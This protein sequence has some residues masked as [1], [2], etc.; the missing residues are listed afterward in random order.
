MRAMVYHQYGT[1]D[2]LQLQ[3]IP[4]PAVRD[5]QVL[6]S[7][8]AASVNAIDWH[9]LAGTPF[10]AR[11]MAGGLFKPKNGVLG[12]DLAGRVEATG[13]NVKQFQPGDPVFG[14]TKHGCFAE[15]VCVS[16]EEVVTKPAS[17]TFEEAAAAGAAAFTALQGLRDKGQIKR[18]QK[19]LINGASGDVGTFAVQ[20]ARSF[21]AEVTGV[22]ST[23][24]LDMVRSMGADHVMD[25]TQE[26]FTQK[27]QRYD[28]IFDV[29]AK[30]SFG[31]CRRALSPE[32][33]YVTTEF[34]P[35]LALV[36]LW[37]SIT[38]KQ[39][40]VPLLA[41]PPNK[42][43]LLFLQELLAAGQV[44]PVIDRRYP[45]AELPDAL[46][47]LQKGQA[48]GKLVITLS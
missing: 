10:M 42:K 12:T 3:E 43:D 4:V 33:I 27:G 39:K 38:G 31:D 11:I 22:C 18:G 9:F 16:E 48:R 40:M 13:A 14:S 37:R 25:Y 8:H 35:V 2:N 44:T 1:P 17:I 30:R 47:Y 36:G 45:L 26:D 28:L 15:Y 19:V 46:R 41:T 6:V 23:T 5:D 20:I 24:N 7:V 21:G 34:S 32:G 29:A